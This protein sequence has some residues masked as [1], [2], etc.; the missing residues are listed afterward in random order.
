MLSKERCDE[1]LGLLLCNLLK[2][3][4]EPDVA[5]PNCHV[6]E[7]RFFFIQKF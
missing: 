1:K 7:N 3:K 2:K 5:N 6:K 4:M